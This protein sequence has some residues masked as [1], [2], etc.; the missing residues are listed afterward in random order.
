[1]TLSSDEFIKDLSIL[2]RDDILIVDNSL[3]A[4]RQTEALIPII[5]YYGDE[6]DT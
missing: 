3:I 2:N 1:M 5:P 4:V 6:A